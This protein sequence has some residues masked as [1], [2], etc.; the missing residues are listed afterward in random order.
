MVVLVCLLFSPPSPNHGSRKP[1]TNLKCVKSKYEQYDQKI[2][3]LAISSATEL[4]MV[5]VYRSFKDLGNGN[6]LYHL[7]TRWAKQILTNDQCV[8][9]KSEIRQL[10]KFVH[11]RVGVGSICA[12]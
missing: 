9:W 3:S 7:W 8:E 1:F 4:A 10:C 12:A 6:N 2:R 11:Q 5:D